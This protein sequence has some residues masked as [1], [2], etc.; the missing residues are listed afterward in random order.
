MSSTTGYADFHIVGTTALDAE[1]RVIVSFNQVPATGSYT[2]ALS[3]RWVMDGTDYRLH[4]NVLAGGSVDVLIERGSSATYDTLAAG[5]ST[6]AVTPNAGLALA[7]QATGA[8]PT[9]LCG[10][11]WLASMAEP[12]AC[13][14]SVQDSTS[15]LQVPGISYLVTFDTGAATPTVSFA[16]FRYLRTGAM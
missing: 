16:T 11:L 1:S 4:V 6:I 5:T 12:S 13:T 9:T 10:K 8:S 2:A 15:Q 3:V 7:L 14:V